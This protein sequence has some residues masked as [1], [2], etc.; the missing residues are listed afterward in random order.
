MLRKVPSAHLA[1]SAPSSLL[2]RKTRFGLRAL[3]PTFAVH[4]DFD[5]SDVIIINVD[6][7]DGFSFGSQHRLHAFFNVQ[8]NSCWLMNRAQLTSI[9]ARSL[10]E[11][12]CCGSDQVPAALVPCVPPALLEPELLLA[13]IRP[14]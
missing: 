7:A 5:G 12:W 3:I 9:Q 10:R 11:K 14:Y 13:L 4:H 1:P 2:F 6:S 8:E